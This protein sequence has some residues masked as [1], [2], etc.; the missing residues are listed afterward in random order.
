MKVIDLSVEITNQMDVYPGDPEVSLEHIQ[1]IESH[2]YNLMQLSLG[3]HTGTHV[4]AYSHMHDDLASIDEISIDKF[5]GLAQ[6]V[7]SFDEFPMNIGLFFIEEIGISMLDKII[8]ANATFVGGNI[9]ID[10]ERG[11]L[12]NKI[13]TY[14][15]LVNLNLIPLNKNFMFYGLPLKISG[16]DGSPVRAIAIVE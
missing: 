5:F 14:T 10:L 16:G 13:I 2:G 15:N 12:K 9:H 1:T 7:D 3:S 8:A 11:L 6:V 4:D